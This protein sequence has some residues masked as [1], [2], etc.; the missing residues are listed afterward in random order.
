MKYIKS[1]YSIWAYILADFFL[2]KFYKNSFDKQ[3]AAVKAESESYKNQITQLEKEV[4]AKER[5]SRVQVI[6]LFLSIFLFFLPCLA[7]NLDQTL[8]GGGEKAP[9]NV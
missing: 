9:A 4:E 8:G 3:L 1:K 7:V 6:T 2:L 5:L